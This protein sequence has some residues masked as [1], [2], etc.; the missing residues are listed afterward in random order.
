MQFGI[1]EY[2]S[3]EICV[4]KVAVCEIC[5]AEITILEACPF[6]IGAAEKTV[7]ELRSLKI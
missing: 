3:R 2:G 7:L 4:S 6:K 5:C 1:G